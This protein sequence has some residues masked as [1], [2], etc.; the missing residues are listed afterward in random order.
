MRDSTL[1]AADYQKQGTFYIGIVNAYGVFGFVGGDYGK[2]LFMKEL[3]RFGAV[4]YKY[5]EK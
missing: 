2:V 5:F 3:C 1:F 4:G